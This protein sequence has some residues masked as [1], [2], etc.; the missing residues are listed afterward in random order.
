[1]DNSPRQSLLP[2]CQN[3]NQHRSTTDL[4][5]K[6]RAEARKAKQQAARSKLNLIARQ[7]YELKYDHEWQEQQLRTL[8]HHGDQI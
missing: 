5:P 8:L 4:L 2:H 7:L 6:S 1:M 3:F